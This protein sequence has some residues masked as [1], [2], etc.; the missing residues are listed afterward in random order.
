M[1]PEAFSANLVE[2]TKS[3][4]QLDEKWLLSLLPSLANVAGSAMGATVKMEFLKAELQKDPRTALQ[5]IIEAYSKLVKEAKRN[6]KADD[7]WPVIIIDEANEL[8]KWEDMKT[9]TALLNFFVYLTK[10]EQLAHV[11]LATSDTFLTQWLESGTAC[12]KLALRRVQMFT[13]QRALAGPI[14]SPFRSSFVVGNL[15]REEAR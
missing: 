5:T 8:M 10:E 1:S 4:W 9:L 3:D 2:C 14:K 6:R 13:A 11:V 15:S 12:Y 7:P